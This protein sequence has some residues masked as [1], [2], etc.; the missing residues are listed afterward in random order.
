M[1]GFQ[2]LVGGFHRLEVAATT[3]IDRNLPC[4]D[5]NGTKDRNLEQIS[6]GKKMWTA[7]DFEE[8]RIGNRERVKMGHVIEAQ[9]VG[10]LFGKL[11]D[12]LYF[13]AKQEANQRS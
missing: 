2:E 8:S 10:A 12:A 5:Q 7:L 1:S 3:A 9:N 11:F 4:S 6:L 13:D